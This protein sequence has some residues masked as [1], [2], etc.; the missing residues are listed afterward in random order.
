VDRGNT[1]VL[2]RPVAIP[3][4]LFVAASAW[5]S[6]V[7][8]GLVQLVIIRVLLSYLGAPQYAL[9]SVVAS[10]GTWFALVEFGVGNSVQNRI[11]AARAAGHERDVVLRS[12]LPLLAGLLV[13]STIAL[14]IVGPP[15][16]RFLFRRIGVSGGGPIGDY[17]IAVIGFV[18]IVTTLVNVS[19]KVF[20]GELRGY[21]ANAYITIANLLLLT[22][23]ILLQ[24]VH[25]ESSR[26]FWALL[27][28]TVPPAIVGVVGS[29][30]VYRRYRLSGTAVDW[31]VTRA[32]WNRAW[33]FG[34]FAAMSAAVLGIDYVIMSQTLPPAQIVQYNAASKVF[35][36][37]FFLYSSVLQASWPVCA[38]ALG[39]RDVSAV[40]KLTRENLAAGTALML[41]GTLAFVAG[42]SLIGGAL[43]GS[44][45]IA[46]PSGVIVAFGAYF[47]LR[48]WAETFATLLMS[49][50]RLR[51]FW[52]YLPFQAAISALGQYSLSRY[53]GLYGI[54]AGLILS[55]LLTAVWVLPWD[56]LKLLRQVSRAK[57]AA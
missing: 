29:I 19:Y 20:Y 13:T 23:V 6:R 48:V 17:V 25:L 11:S 49:G 45:G 37:I 8:G 33:R 10:L 5:A 54:L 4:H 2:R 27:A 22:T 9:F 51:V 56:S 21:I 53:F 32:L 28:C 12:A 39:R 46:I 50:D 7:V 55:F 52:I 34:G 38:E 44:G 57:A 3:A 24:L 47:L 1:S 40:R 14:V 16:Q 36:L 41:V 15:L 43:L 26:L 18:Y 30:Q 35:G 31:G 42:R